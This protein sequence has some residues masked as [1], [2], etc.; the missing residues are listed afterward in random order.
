M[1]VTSGIA[2]PLRSV[3]VP[4]IDPVIPARAIN[5]AERAATATM[6]FEMNLCAVPCSNSFT[7][8]RSYVTEV[9]EITWPLMS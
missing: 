6:R 2:A 3:T 5:A 4:E 1:T 7:S 8:K 9:T